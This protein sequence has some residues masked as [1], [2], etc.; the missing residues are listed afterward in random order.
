MDPRAQFCHTPTCR[1]YGQ[2]G[3]DTIRVHSRKARRY[4]CTVCRATFAETKATPLY[5]AHVAVEQIVRVLTLLA[6]GC[7]L[8]AIVAAF[9]YDERTV[10]AWLVRAGQH[11]EQVHAHLVEAGRVELGV[12]QADELWVKM[13]GR[14]VWLAMAMAVPSRLWLGGELSGQRD[15]VLIGRLVARVR[16]AACSLGVVVCVDGLAS[17][18]TA[19]SRAFRVAERTGRRGHPRLRPAPG[20]GLGQVVKRRV[21]HVVVEVTQRAVVGPLAE[22]TAAL[23]AVGGGTGLNTAYIER[24]N[25]TFRTRMAPLARRCRRLVRSDATLHAW[26]YL[27]GTTY[28]FCQPHRSLRQRLPAA[29]P[30]GWRARTPAMAAGL[31]DHVWSVEELLRWTVPR[32]RRWHWDRRTKQISATFAPRGL[33]PDAA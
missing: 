10:R 21:K 6:H 33:V 8:A 24:L 7:P 30:T 26:T 18:V 23:V 29:D 5:R 19:F 22:L 11:S 13:V 17:Y 1:A 16:A 9:G 20:F 25:A 15:G 2:R 4:R 31:T 14:K 12:V 3:V 32:P 28:N 27:V